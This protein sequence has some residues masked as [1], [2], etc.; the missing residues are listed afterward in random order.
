MGEAVA[1][2]LL[3]RVSH[4]GGGLL[5]KGEV[6]GFAADVAL[7]LVR[8][9]LARPVLGGLCYPAL[10]EDDLMSEEKKSVAAP[11]ADKMVGGQ[12]KSREQLRKK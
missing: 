3:A 1:V 11:P 5:R 6:A 9:G 10:E 4:R 12:N 2:E 7:D 8:R